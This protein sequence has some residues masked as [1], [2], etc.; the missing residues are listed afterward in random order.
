MLLAASPDMNLGAPLH[1][2][3][4]NACHFNTGTGADG[5]FPELVGNSNVLADEPSGFLQ[6][7]LNGAAMPSTATRPAR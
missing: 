1:L 5:V 3:N 4:C 6:V 7:I 2:D